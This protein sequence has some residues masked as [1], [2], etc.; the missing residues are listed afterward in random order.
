MSTT[1]VL[2]G[3]K[4]SIDSSANDEFFRQSI[5]L[6]EKNTIHIVL[7]YW[8]R[9]RER[10]DA[11]AERNK[12][13]I[14]KQTSKYVKFS[15]TKDIADLYTQL[16][17]ADVLYVEGGEAELI[18]PYLPQLLGLKEKLQDKVYLGSSMGAFIVA[19][20]YVLS[21][22]PQKENT[23]HHGLGLL[24]ISVLCHWNVE[25]KKGL[26]MDL[27]RKEDARL[28]IL[29]LDEQKFATFVF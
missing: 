14:T 7:C 15:I 27:L 16:E 24:P 9:P 19:T 22:S 2:Y 10:W 4:T 3:G 18:E 12:K 26:K 29:L 13:S 28:P 8:A 5:D 6:V 20:H 11:L 17:H 1:F 21:L 25:K 23:V